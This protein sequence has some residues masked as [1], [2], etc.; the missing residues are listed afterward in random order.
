VLSLSNTTPA[1]PSD[2]RCDQRTR[3]TSSHDTCGIASA[4]SVTDDLKKSAIPAVFMLCM[5]FPYALG[6]CA[7]AAA[8]LVDASSLDMLRVCVARLLRLCARASLDSFVRASFAVVFVRV[9]SFVAIDGATDMDGRR[10][11]LLALRI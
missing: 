11:G 2:F 7:G 5:S 3:D 6:A 10:M 9:R 1:N 4:R 8:S